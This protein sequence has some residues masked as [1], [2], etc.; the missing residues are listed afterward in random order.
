MRES[1]EPVLVEESADFAV[2]WK[3]PRMHCAPLKGGGGTLL[4]WYAAR[5]PPVRDMP[6]RSAGEGGLVHRLDFETQGLVLF[7]KNQ[8]TLD[9]FLA[10]QAEGSFV[11]EYRARCVKTTCRLPGFP[12]PPAA[13]VFS[14]NTAPL[15]LC[16]ESF[17]RPYGPGRKQVRPLN[18]AD[19]ARWELAA[20]RGGP[21]RTEIRE[22]SA[23]FPGGPEEDGPIAHN[24]PG[25]EALFGFTLRLRRGF[26]HQIRC[27]LAWIGYPIVNDPL[28]GTD[29][30]GPLGL[31]SC[32]LFFPDP[33]SGENRECRAGKGLIQPAI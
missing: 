6:G 28:Y 22:F 16:I 1:P 31:S 18:G 30:G 29:G 10:R 33:R 13:P 24:G 14:A 12:P 26:R 3:P 15:P 4:D 20:D 5:F 19:P 23:L 25:S 9:F 11:K 8:R 27:H 21:Y 2:V 17:F 32:G 7:A